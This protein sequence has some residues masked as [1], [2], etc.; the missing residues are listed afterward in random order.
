MAHT[1]YKVK[2]KRV[3]SVTTI[4]GQQLGWNK[5]VLLGWTRKNC[6]Q[7]NDSL[8]ILRDAGAIGTL[9]HNLIDAHTRGGVV[10]LDNYEP[11]QVSKAK[12]AFY[13]FLDWKENRNVKIL[14]SESKMVSE[15]YGFG[16][17]CD[18]IA[19][20]NGV[21]VILDYKTS[22]NCY[23]EYIIQLAAYRQM[24][25]EANPKNKIKTGIVLKL[26]KNKQEWTEH[27]VSPKNLLWGWNIFKLLLKLDMY[28]NKGEHKW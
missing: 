23:D 9:A 14:E 15:K 19:T 7:G 24:W 3:K 27:T 21:S 25:N 26:N 20:V 11:V 28:K 17:T 6:L 12:T 13:A 18:G 22:N 1:V 10:T 5:Q 8:K 4:I 2:D 16:G